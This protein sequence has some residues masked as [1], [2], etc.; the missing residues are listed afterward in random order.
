MFQKPIIWKSARTTKGAFC[1]TAEIK[2]DRYKTCLFNLDVD[3]RFNT[4]N[5]PNCGI[6]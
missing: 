3:V 6:A 2:K 5:S 4:P 1:P